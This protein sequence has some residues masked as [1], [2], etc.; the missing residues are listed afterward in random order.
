MGSC[1]SKKTEKLEPQRFGSLKSDYIPTTCRRA[2]W[3]QM[4]NIKNFSM[5]DVED[6]L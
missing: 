3:F 1:F 5:Q 6:I 2:S 4:N